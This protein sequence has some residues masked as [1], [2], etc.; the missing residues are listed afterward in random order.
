M[1]H[2][3]Y[4]SEFST[5]RVHVYQCAH[6]NDAA[7]DADCGR[8]SCRLCKNLIRL[9]AI[10][11]STDAL[12]VVVQMKFTSVPRTLKMCETAYCHVMVSHFPPSTH[13]CR[14]FQPCIFYGVAISVLALRESCLAN[15]YQVWYP[16][17]REL[18]C[19]Q[20]VR[21]TDRRT[22]R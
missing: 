4:L 6:T 17:V 16:R 5:K 10:T 22:H 21:H 11:V 14:V 2:L 3:N 7:L 15:A 8:T 13:W 20:I 12:S 19:G 1:S 9:V 18:S